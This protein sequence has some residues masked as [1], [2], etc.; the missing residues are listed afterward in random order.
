MSSLHLPVKNVLVNEV[1]LIPMVRTNEIARLVII[2]Q[3]FPYMLTTV[4]FLS[5]LKYLYLFTVG[6]V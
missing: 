5:L 2:T 3:H 6:L 4:K 1:K